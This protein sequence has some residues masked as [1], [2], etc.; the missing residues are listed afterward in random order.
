MNSLGVQD[1]LCGGVCTAEN[2]N[3]AFGRPPKNKTAL[4]VHIPR[5]IGDKCGMALATGAA[6]GTLASENRR[7]APFR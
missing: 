6:G 4:S 2:F 5:V 7:L 1:T 3:T